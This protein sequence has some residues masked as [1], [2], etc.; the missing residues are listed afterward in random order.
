MGNENHIVTPPDCFMEPSMVHDTRVTL[1][2]KEHRELFKQLA[3]ALAGRTD[4]DIKLVAQHA[5][6]LAETILTV[7]D[8]IGGNNKK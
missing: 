2:V 8:T 4:Y 7:A 1:H 3:A 5:K 6:A